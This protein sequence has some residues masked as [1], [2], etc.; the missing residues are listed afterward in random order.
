MIGVLVSGEGTNLQALLDARGFEIG[1]ADG[2]F[3]LDLYA[4]VVLRATAGGGDWEAS[5]CP[6]HTDFRR[7]LY[8]DR[9]R[10]AE[11]R[12][13]HGRSRRHDGSRPA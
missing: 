10:E 1:P 12:R 3:G 8:R 2:V 4:V 13:Q 5:I 6:R 11:W 9:R 7:R